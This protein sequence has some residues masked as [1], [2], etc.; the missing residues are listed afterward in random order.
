[1]QKKAMD[2]TIT[3]EIKE[4]KQKEKE[5]KRLVDVGFVVD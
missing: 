1:M 4:D 2:K 5:D 3:K